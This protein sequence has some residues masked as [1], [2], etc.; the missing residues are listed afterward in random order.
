PLGRRIGGE[1]FQPDAVQAVI[2][3]RKARPVMHGLIVVDDGDLPFAHGRVIRNWPGVVDQVED[4]V[5]FG[6][7]AFPSKISGA[8]PFATRGIIM[9][10]VV[11]CPSLDS[12]IMR[13][14]SCWVTRL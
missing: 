1:D 10:K 6:H 9:R 13:P 3:Q 12:S 14:P 11:P 4:I 7:S 8:A 5:L 2:G